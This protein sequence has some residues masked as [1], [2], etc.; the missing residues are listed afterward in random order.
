[1]I[2]SV[3]RSVGKSV[4]NAITGA[5]GSFS[6]S[7]WW[8][9]RYPSG[10]TLT[11]DSD[12]QITLTWTNN[13]DVDYDGVSIE[14]S[15]DG[16]T[17]VEIDTAAAGSVTYV[18]A[19]LTEK[20]QY[21]YR[22]RYYSGT[23]YSAY[24]GV[25]NDWTAILM[26]LTSTGT[27]VGVS[28]V[29]F[30]FGTVDTVVTLSGTGKWYSDAAGTLDE[31]TS[32][33]FV[34]GALRTRYLKVTAGTSNMLV[35]AKNNNWLRW[36]DNTADGFTSAA[37]AATIAKDISALT[38]LTYLRVTGNNTLSGSIAALT[39]LTYLYVLGTNTLSGSIAAL[40]SLTFLYVTGTNTLSGS[41]AALIS[42]TYLRISGSNTISG[43][44]GASRV[45]EGITG[46]FNL[47]PCGMDTYTGGV[48]GWENVNV[49]INPAAPAG[50]SG[51]E[52]D[53]ILI[54]MANDPSMVS[55][56]ITLQGSSAA[57]TAG[58]NA[59]VATLTGVGRTNIVVTN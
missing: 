54:D 44:L 35:F 43:D 28:T 38:S 19:G 2:R 14:R 51:T 36:G 31:S 58:S 26:V 47:V 21:Y 6:W 52:V 49:T 4:A 53:N 42:L 39:S 41:V 29:R 18:S 48:T 22:V 8:A 13:G 17:Y 33:T 50:Y 11:V 9:S 46:Y 10:L 55:K 57:R 37:N 16:V 12:T 25:A 3:V 5:G 27:G 24:S 20:T 15:T 34:Q 45:P 59:A 40:T 23:H 1:M 30:Y 7:A 32:Y 56:T